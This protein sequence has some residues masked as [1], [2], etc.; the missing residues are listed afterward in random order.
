[1]E[2]TYPAAAAAA[3]ASS[4]LRERADPFYLLM[5]NHSERFVL[6]ISWDD[7]KVRRGAAQK[8]RNLC[9][10]LAYDEWDHS[11]LIER[12]IEKAVNDH[13]RCYGLAV[14]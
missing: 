13:K 2:R 5:F 7:K 3:A 12:R 10:F 1:M 4:I 11:L 14:E 8:G 9:T 6:W